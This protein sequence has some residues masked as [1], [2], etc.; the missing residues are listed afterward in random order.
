MTLNEMLNIIRQAL[1]N[2]SVGE[3]N[4]GQVVIYTD[5]RLDSQE[6]L[7]PIEEA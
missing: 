3:D 6:N 7:V 4:D 5:K 2:A 1:P